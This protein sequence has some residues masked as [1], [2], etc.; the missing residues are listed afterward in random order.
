MVI[1]KQIAA[2]RRINARSGAVPS[3]TMA[4][5]TI[6]LSSDREI[7]AGTSLLYLK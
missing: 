1:Y 6:R 3:M 5:E 4:I 2:M 7:F